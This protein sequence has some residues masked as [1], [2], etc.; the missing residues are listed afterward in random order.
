MYLMEII[1]K[2]SSLQDCWYKSAYMYP[3]ISIAGSFSLGG[4]RVKLV[5]ILYIGRLVLK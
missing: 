4:L 3:Q 1:M 5:Y 2:V